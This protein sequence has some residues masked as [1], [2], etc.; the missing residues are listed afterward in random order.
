[1]TCYS[2]GIDLHSNNGMV[3]VSDEA[4]RVRYQRRLP[5][6]LAKILAALEPHRAELAG[7]AV[8]S[9]YNWY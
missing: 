8:E 2:A 5:N 6:E 1:M 9:T 7:V 3:M 4:D